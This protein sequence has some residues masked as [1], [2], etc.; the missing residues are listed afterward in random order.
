[1]RNWQKASILLVVFA[2]IFSWLFFAAR[3]SVEPQTLKIVNTPF[4][5]KFYLN[6][7]QDP[8]LYWSWPKIPGLNWGQTKEN[9]LLEDLNFKIAVELSMTDP[10]KSLLVEM[11]GRIKVSDWQKFLS[12]TESKE[13]TRKEA[14]QLLASRKLLQESGILFLLP[15]FEAR[16]AFTNRIL[17][18][19]FFMGAIEVEEF[20]YKNLPWY[21]DFGPQGFKYLY[22]KAMQTPPQLR[23]SLEQ[24]IIKAQLHDN[25]TVDLKP[26]MLLA[27]RMN[28]GVLQSYLDFKIDPKTGESLTEAYKSGKTL[29]SQF[30]TGLG[31]DHQKELAKMSVAEIEGKIQ[32]FLKGLPEKQ[33]PFTES[34]FALMVANEW[35]NTHLRIY[36]EIFDKELYPF[37]S[38]LPQYRNEVN[39]GLWKL[40]IQNSFYA[41]PNDPKLQSLELE[42]VFSDWFKKE[43]VGLL[44]TELVELFQQD[45]FATIEDFEISVR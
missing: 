16:R 36:Q 4:G 30:L 37:F 43:G 8:K 33:T 9:F 31:A 3:I 17:T 24:M 20:I 34:A 7:S 25:F 19:R 41:L 10:A 42:K 26:V 1:M 6:E 35:I 27:L 44:K 45:G 14:I 38:G 2:V 32:N 23:F 5:E 11:S 39:I 28:E 29:Q 18:T 13:S 15:E 12:S 40:A 22:E 21:W